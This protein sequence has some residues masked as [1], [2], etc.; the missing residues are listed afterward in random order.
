MQQEENMQ[1]QFKK[2]LMRLCLTARQ[3][4][5][6]SQTTYASRTDK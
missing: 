3:Y 6:T 4:A 5:R 1:Q 2:Q